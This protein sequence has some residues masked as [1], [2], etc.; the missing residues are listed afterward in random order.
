[1][2]TSYCVMTVY[3]LFQCCICCIYQLYV[4]ILVCSKRVGSNCIL[5]RTLR[6]YINTVLLLLILAEY[7]LALRGSIVE[8]IKLDI[9]N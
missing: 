8:W 9:P 4:Y 3:C 2:M 5:Y 7:P 6:R 1:M